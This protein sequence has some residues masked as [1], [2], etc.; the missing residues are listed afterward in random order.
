MLLFRKYNIVGRTKI[1]IARR[2]SKTVE[3]DEKN[4]LINQGSI[5]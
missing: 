3:E 5:N 4:E 1:N 2:S